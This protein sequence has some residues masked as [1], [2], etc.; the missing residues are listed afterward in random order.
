MAAKK[1]LNLKVFDKL[2]EACGRIETIVHLGGM[3]ADT[4]AFPEPLNDLLEESDE[5]LQHP[6]PDL[7][8]WVREALGCEDFERND[9]FSQWI[10]Q[11]GRL[12]F[13]V[14]FATPVMT[15]IAKGHT[16]YSWSYYTT[17]WLYGNSLEDAIAAGLAWIQ[18]QRSDEMKESVKTP[19]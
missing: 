14:K 17:R 2:S 9:M 7:P 4:E 5:T 11:T 15:H 3:T 8:D 16:R 18:K 1:P 19:T 6:F 13:V 12:G 10:H